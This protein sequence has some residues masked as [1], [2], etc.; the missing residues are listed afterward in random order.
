LE[1]LV[2]SDELEASSKTQIKPL[3]DAKK[4]ANPLIE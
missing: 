4:G 2:I 1:K 3:G